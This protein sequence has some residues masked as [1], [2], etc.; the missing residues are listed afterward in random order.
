MKTTDEQKMIALIKDN[1]SEGIKLFVAYFYQRIFQIVYFKLGNSLKNRQDCEDLTSEIVWDGI[2]KIQNGGFDPEKGRLTQYIYGIIN[3]SC[4]NFFK[5]S[6]IR[7][8]K[9]FSDYQY[10]SDSIDPQSVIENNIS[11]IEFQKKAEREKAYEIQA[12]I[13]GA[14]EKM[15]E[16]YKKLIYLKY[17][18]NLS[19][20]EISSEEA[21]PVKK[22]KSRLFDARRK[23]EIIII[24]MI[25]SGPNISA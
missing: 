12:L 21:I 4:K 15:D 11:L 5:K 16:K 13:S 19:Y 18:K 25:N 20:Q 2:V 14:I 24:K 1:D 6:K 22:V 23:L 8:E 10:G 9:R 3:N 17:Y 7:A